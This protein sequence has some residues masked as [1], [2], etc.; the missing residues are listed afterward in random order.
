MCAFIS[1]DRIIVGP[2]RGKYP[3][4]HTGMC[5]DILPISQ[6]YDRDSLGMRISGA[7]SGR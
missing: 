1:V 4:N 3:G 5:G 6:S 2:K 7:S